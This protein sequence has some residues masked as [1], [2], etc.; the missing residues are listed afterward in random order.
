MKR[1]KR[2]QA[3][4]VN[5][6]DASLVVLV[7]IGA[8]LLYVL[9]VP[10]DI[11]EDLLNDNETESNG[12]GDNNDTDIVK[13]LLKEEPGRIDY[14][15]E[16]E[17]EHTIPSFYLYKTTDS[18]ELKKINPF[19]IKKTSFDSKT[20]NITF[21]INDLENTKK[22]ILSFQAKTHKGLLTIRLNGY[23]ILVDDI[24]VYNPNPVSLPQELL[25]EI[26]VLEFS[27]SGV[28]WQFWK[29]NEYN[30]E[31]I[32]LIGDVT[33]VSRQE[34]KNVFYL[35]EVEYNNL[36]RVQ[37]KFLPECRPSRVGNLQVLV[38]FQEVFNGIP[39]CG[40]LN[41]YEISP[42][43]LEKGTNRVVFKTDEGDYL[44]DRLMI[45]TKLKPAPELVY[46]FNVNDDQWKAID[47]NEYDVNL[48]VEFV[49]K[50]ELKEGRFI[51]N[52]KETGLYTKDRIYSRKIN[53][54]MQEEG[55]SL[56]IV[57]RSKLDIVQVLVLLD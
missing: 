29:T 49:E 56:K 36:E 10:P 21:K 5:A 26:N 14:L 45:K 6:G 30:L 40:I 7:I 24:R 27:V 12:S 32:R 44:I 8:I 2:A 31:N 48:T 53:H 17:Y 47:D 37:L 20:K 52:G 25:K 11:R 43:K 1:K 42:D 54:F 39:D 57:P 51:I 19:Y 13:V 16:D 41:V 28:G 22:V 23:E 55:N 38:N 4:V 3:N 50:G 15:S 34:S 9:L 46:Y 33:D 35:T 18:E